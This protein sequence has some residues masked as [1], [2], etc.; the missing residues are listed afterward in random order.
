[1]GGDNAPGEI[2]QGAADAARGGLPVVLVGPEA[3][4]REEL[5]RRGATETERTREEA[6]LTA[7]HEASE[8]LARA[9]EE[10]EQIVAAA[11]RERARL[12]E[13]LARERAA[14]EATRL[15]LSDLLGDLLRDLGAE[16]ALRQPAPGDAGEE[17]SLKPAAA[18][19]SASG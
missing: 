19:R 9:R 13:A 18:P 2:I 3:V 7:E 11:D 10:A 12:L 5:S 6:A 8:L 14:V 15:R 17:A 4:V 16:P 1:M